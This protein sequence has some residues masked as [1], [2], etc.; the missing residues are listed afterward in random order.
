MTV[1]DADF[2][3]LSTPT[4]ATGSP[5]AV[6]YRG[7]NVSVLSDRMLRNSTIANA[8][9][10]RPSIPRNAASPRRHSATPGVTAVRAL[11]GI[12]GVNQTATIAASGV[13][14]SQRSV[15]SMPIRSANAPPANAP[16]A[17]PA[18]SAAVYHPNTTP[19]RRP[20]L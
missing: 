19:A 9:H 20:P 4:N 13:S 18:E 7:K 8:S 1:A 16:S 5:I 14:P 17:Y 2:D 10:T 3:A 15:A 11:S 6:P 12:G